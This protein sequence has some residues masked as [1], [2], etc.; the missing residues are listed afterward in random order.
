M[1]ENDQ[2]AQPPATITAAI[3]RLDEII[4]TLPKR[5]DQCATF[6]RRNLHLV[7][8]STVSDMAKAAGVAP[9][10]YMRFCQVFGFGGYSDMQA[11]FREQYTSFRPDYEERLATLRSDQDH[12]SG[13]LLADFAEAGQKS[14]ISLGNS[15]ANDGLIK[16]AEGLSQARIVHLIGARRA[17]A[18][19]SNMAYLLENL[20]VPTH[21]HT[22]VGHLSNH[23]LVSPEDAM[24]A[25]TFAPFS[26]T[27]INDARIAA[28]RGATVF[29]LTDSEKCPLFEFATETLVVR[30]HEVAGFRSLNASLTLTTA[31]SVLTA[32]KRKAT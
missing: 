5:M 11:L 26:Q 25:V 30:E 9:S 10:V 12:S 29:G 6:T 22:H 1:T 2:Q 18:V 7:A 21:L 13:Q 14:L 8:V 16:V 19:V 24:L 17:F 31:L 28:E 27:T 3:N 4:G 15:V 32:E 20:D 23:H